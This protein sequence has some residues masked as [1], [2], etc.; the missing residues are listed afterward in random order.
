MYQGVLTRFSPG[1]RF[2]RGSGSERERRGAP[3]VGQSWSP[4]VADIIGPRRAWMV[5]MIS[6]VSMPCR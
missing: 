3:A 2:A 1:A 6:S 5:A 4:A